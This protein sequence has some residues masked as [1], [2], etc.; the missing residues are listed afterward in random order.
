MDITI[1]FKVTSATKRNRP[2]S[3][4][5]STYKCVFY[6]QRKFR[7]SSYYYYYTFF[8]FF[9]KSGERQPIAQ[10]AISDITLPQFIIVFSICIV[11]LF[12]YESI[13]P[14]YRLMLF[15]KRFLEQ[16]SQVWNAYLLTEGDKSDTL[17]R[18][19]TMFD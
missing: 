11:F 5:Q 1:T 18:L 14:V 19:Y 3:L 6:W 16:L 15:S 12:V 7:L 10:V 9:F 4:E 2:P 8:L 17:L 13:W